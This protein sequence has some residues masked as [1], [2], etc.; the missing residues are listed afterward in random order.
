MASGAAWS[1]QEAAVWRIL[2]AAPGGPD[3]PAVP[4]GKR[5]GG[6]CLWDEKCH[7]GTGGGEGPCPQ[8]AQRQ[9]TGYRAGG[10]PHGSGGAPPFRGGAHL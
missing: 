8:A 1:C 2:R 9:C 7:S 10:D 4:H 3:G 6:L 5:G